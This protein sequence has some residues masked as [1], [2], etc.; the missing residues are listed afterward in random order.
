[1]KIINITRN[2]ASILLSALI[3]GLLL[4]ILIPLSDEP[5]YL[6]RV[7]AIFNSYFKIWSPFIVVPDSQKKLM[8]D[9]S[10]EITASIPGLYYKID[11]NFCKSDV[12]TIAYRCLVFSVHLVSIGIFLG[13]LS[14][15]RKCDNSL[16]GSQLHIN[17]TFLTVLMP[18][19]LYYISAFSFEAWA[20]IFSTLAIFMLHRP[21]LYLLI[22]LYIYIYDSGSA[23]LIL[24]FFTFRFL[25]K[26]ILH[27]IGGKAALFTLGAS[28]GVLYFSG[29]W[30]IQNAGGLAKFSSELAGLTAA[31]NSDRG[32]DII[33][34]YPLIA[35]P[36]ITF[37]TFCF[38]TPAQMFL[39][40]LTII[41]GYLLLREI[42]ASKRYLKTGFGCGGSFDRDMY[43]EFYCALAFIVSSIFILPGYASA[44]YYMFL[45]PILISP[46]VFRYGLYKPFLFFVIA[47]L[48]II[49][50]F[51]V[52]R[53]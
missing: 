50:M 6:I 36:V 45:G 44:K 12:S 49:I 48:L 13:L 40:P 28:V 34:K 42:S 26:S 18:A 17:S 32:I 19:Y 35:R 43:F 27:S 29:T 52:S 11:G 16:V 41:T 38:M 47:N 1:M 23:L 24:S 30:I 53:V 5:D 14:H 7:D 20:L 10:C 3:F 37:L 46:I 2:Q 21:L 15:R 33:E 22:G 39:M 8:M 9:I 25:L 31:Y 4:R 51:I